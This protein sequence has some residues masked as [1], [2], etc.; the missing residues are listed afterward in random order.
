MTGNLGPVDRLEVRWVAGSDRERLPATGVVESLLLW[1]VEPAGD[2]LR[3]RLTYRK[4]EGTSLIRLRLDPGLVVRSVSIPGQADAAIQTSEKGVEWVA[5]VSPPL[6]DGASI[7]I[8]L[9]RPLVRPAT[10]ENEEPPAR[11]SA[12][13]RA[14]GGGQLLGSRRLPPAGRVGGAAG[15]IDGERR[16]H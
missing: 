15:G 12:Q 2:R 7:R 4:P 13:D 8:E 6:P 10:A 14:V 1:D 5:H 9:W 3:A 16:D 11:S